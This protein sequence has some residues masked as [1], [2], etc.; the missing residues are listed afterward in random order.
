MKIVLFALLVAACFASGFNPRE[1]NG[2]IKFS[3]D[4]HENSPIGLFVEGLLDPR[5]ETNNNIQAFLKLA[6]QYIPILQSVSNMNNDLTYS[7]TYH[8]NFAG[9]D[10][11]VYYEL[12]LIVGWRVKPGSYSS[13]FYEVT[14]TPFVFGETHGNATGQTWPAAGMVRGGLL[15]A[16]AYAPIGVT[17]YKEGKICFGGRYTVEP[18]GLRTDVSA[19]L[20]GCEAEII[21]EVIEG[22]PIH[23]GCNYTAPTNFTL[24]HLNFTDTYT[25]DLIPETCFT[26]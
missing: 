5:Q 14:Y 3:M 9:V 11:Y 25:G 23:L 20:K 19:A 1:E 12:Q 8:I 2:Q 6:N 17:L 21:D 10:V 18:V 15:F 26:F 22:Q 7:R 16:H 24:F 13:S 4:V